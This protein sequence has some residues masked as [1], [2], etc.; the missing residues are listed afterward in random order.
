MAQRGPIPAKDADFDDYIQNA[1]PYLN[2]NKTRL[3][4]STAN[5]T[6]LYSLRVQWNVTYPK[7]QDP[8]QRTRSITANK[9]RLK[10]QISSHLR[11]I[12]RD[13][14]ES[15]LISADRETLGLKER[16]IEP[17][18]MPIPDR[19]PDIT[20]DTIRHL[21]HKLRLTDPENPHTQAKPKGVREIEV[22]RFF[23]DEPPPSV[24]DY[25]FVGNATRFLYE[26]GFKKAD[27]GKRVFYI[28]RYVNTRG[29]PGPWSMAVS[30]TVA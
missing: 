17:T 9:R 10:S 27:T 30:A 18:P 5:M 15:V 23:G 12:Y 11:K 26:V 7:S 29:I 4:I 8:N 13:I 25:E 20:I 6:E 21:V 2:D 24:S 14:A 16:D 28:A 1:V 19:A 22:F 3:G